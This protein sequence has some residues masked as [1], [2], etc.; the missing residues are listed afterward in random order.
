M[1]IWGEYRLTGNRTTYAPTNDKSVNCSYDGCISLALDGASDAVPSV[2]VGCAFAANAPCAG[3]AGATGRI[4][5]GASVAYTAYQTWNGNSTM[6]VR[7]PRLQV[8]EPN[9][10]DGLAKL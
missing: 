5:A 6:P 8:T 4:L 2:A 7:V 3:I 1:G 9:H 10:I